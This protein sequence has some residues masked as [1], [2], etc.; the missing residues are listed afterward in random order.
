MPNTHFLI[1]SRQKL[2]KRRRRIHKGGGGRSVFIL[3]FDCIEKFA[4]VEKFHQKK[5]ETERWPVPMTS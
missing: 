1:V 4:L 2:S 3:D 5:K